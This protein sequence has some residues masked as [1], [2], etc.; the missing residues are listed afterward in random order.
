VYLLSGAAIECP[1]EVL[2]RNTNVPVVLPHALG[3]QDII[4][5]PPAFSSIAVVSVRINSDDNVTAI[6]HSCSFSCGVEPTDYM[7]HSP[8]CFSSVATGEQSIPE[9]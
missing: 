6:S 1:E 4:D 2:R 3:Q 8:S 5:R 9:D 7:D